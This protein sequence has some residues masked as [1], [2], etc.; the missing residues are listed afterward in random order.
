METSNVLLRKDVPQEATWNAESVYASRQEWENEL[1]SIQAELS[2]GAQFQGRLAEGA[3]VVADVLEA[4]QEIIR[5]V[6][7]ALMY[8]HISYQVDKTDPQAGAMP[9]KAQALYGQ[10]MAAGAFIEP[11]LIAIGQETLTAWQQSEPR[12]KIYAHYFENLFR[13]QAHVRSPEVE[14]LLGMLAEPFT[15]IETTY[16]MLVDADFTFQPAETLDGQPVAISQSSFM[17]LMS[18]TD[19]RLRQSAWE[20]Y[21]DEYLAHKNTLASNLT[22]SI[23]ANVFYSRARRHA[24]S[25]EASLFE[26]NIP[27]VVFHNLIET[28]RR[29]LPTWQRYFAIRRKALEVDRLEPYDLWAPLTS[30]RP[31]VP[32]HQA[33]E[34]I[35]AGL[36]PLGADYV[37]T[38]RKGCLE[39]RWVDRA[40]NQGKMA[41][42]FSYG[43]PGTHPFIV[44]NYTDEIFSLSTLAHELGHSMHSYLTWKNQPIIYADYSLF[45][46]EVASNFHQAMVRAYLLE[47]NPERD[48]QIGVIEEAMANFYRYFLIMPTLARFEL[49]AHQRIERGAGLSANDLIDLMA[50]LFGEAFGETVHLDRQRV[51]MLWATFSHLYADYYVYQYATGISGAHA[52]SRRILAGTPGAAEDYRRF[53]SAGSSLYPLE[54]LKLAG[55]DL[56][57]PQPVEETFNV[58]AG[59][60]DRLAN[61]LN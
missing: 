5:R 56:T 23:K 49:E 18:S 48:F 44:M 26:H 6:A 55:V 39:Q 14:E 4:R 8:A 40:P 52:L 31:Q 13:K 22:T 45:V 15:N 36:E 58:L 41:G 38:V 25:L 16:G 47:Q 9:G 32:Y 2:R 42:A 28:F 60:V 1:K 34:W 46:A 10:A 21:L 17:K 3:G 53:L 57:T 19:R 59:L 61:L 50:D 29:N 51:G 54:A 33:V 12:L 43:S 35:C 30:S 7:K 20:H 24:D 11:E 27:V 37:E